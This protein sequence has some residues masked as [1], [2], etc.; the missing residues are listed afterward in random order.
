M[1][2]LLVDEIC[3]LLLCACHCGENNQKLMENINAHSLLECFEIMC[4]HCCCHCDS[5]EREHHRSCFTM[6]YFKIL[7]LCYYILQ[8]HAMYYT[9]LRARITVMLTTEKHIFM[10][11]WPPQCQ[12]KIGFEYDVYFFE[13]LHNDH[14][15][16]Y[17][18]SSYD[19][20]FV[21]KIGICN[22]QYNI[23]HCLFFLAHILINT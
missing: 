12:Q 11:L 20:W 7:I 22:F 8:W 19:E 18:S 14:C 3:R 16:N 21:H 2:L 6:P 4:H 17:H 1:P 13:L 9:R 10:A 5:L 15:Y 23:W